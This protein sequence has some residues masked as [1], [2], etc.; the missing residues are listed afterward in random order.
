LIVDDEKA[1]TDVLSET[2]PGYLDA[3][4]V[5]FARPAVALEALPNLDVGV[6]VT[7]YFMPQMNGVEF[8]RRALQLKPETPCVLIT[9]HRDALTN[10][11]LPEMAEL[12]EILAKP[13]SSR[14]LAAAIQKH[15]PR[16]AASGSTTA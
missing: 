5:T 11:G 1:Y 3:P 14:T 4:I 12:K 13:F 8:L 15:W 10:E 16:S 6:I 7:D 2:L 9:G